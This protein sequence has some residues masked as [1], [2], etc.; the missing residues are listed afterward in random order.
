MTSVWAL[1]VITFK[2]GIRTRALYGI[3]LLALILLA[4]NFLV[5]GLIMQDVGKVAV[6]M[7]LSTVSFAGLLVVFF[8]GINLLAKDLERKTIYIVMARPISRSQ[9]IFGKFFGL[10]LLIVTTVLV[11]GAFAIASIFLIKLTYPLYFDRFAWSPVFLAIIFSLF[12]LLLLT[13]LCVL[14]SSFCTSSFV[15][16]ILT[17]VSYIIGQSLGD[18]KALLE[19]PQSLGIDVS[20]VTLK[21]LNISYYLFPNLSFFDLKIQAAHNLPISMDYLFWISVYGIFYSGLAISLAAFI[22]DKKEFQ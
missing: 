5:S 2:E 15:V 9:Y 19:A 6:D 22:F 21:V 3:T 4:A 20:P 1:A 17:I 14:F 8:I 10:G 11:L 16:L 18:V 7:A 13:S 12:S